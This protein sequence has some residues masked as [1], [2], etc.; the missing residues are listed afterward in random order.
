MAA[1]NFTLYNAAKLALFSGTLNMLSDTITAV[2]LKSSYTPS[3]AHATFADVSAQEVTDADY[4]K[5]A[6]SGQTVTGGSGTVTVDTADISFGATVTITAK[7]LALVK[8]AAG[9]I[10]GSSPLIGYCDLNSSG[11]TVSSTS[12]AFA[13]NTPSG[14]FTAA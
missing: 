14:L 9:S 5:K 1:G 11:G 13:V 7:Y 2:L 12:G 8:G 4:A 3:A 10:T 6:V